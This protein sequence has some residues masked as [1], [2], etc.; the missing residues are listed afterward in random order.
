MSFLA[1]SKHLAR[2]WL[3]F[4]RISFIREMEF[5]TNFWMGIT[6]ELLWFAIFLFIIE[7]IFRNTQSLAGWSKSEV[8][9]MLALAR[10]VEGTMNM[11][12]IRNIGEIPQLIQDGMFDYILT[13]PIPAQW[14]AAFKRFMFYNAGMF[15]TGVALL[16]YTFATGAPAPSLPHLLRTLLLL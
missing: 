15:A 16:G 8:L 3:A 2:T 10:C 6:R 4:I 5:R 1:N 7:I 11:V 13:K 14:H 12:F 9:I